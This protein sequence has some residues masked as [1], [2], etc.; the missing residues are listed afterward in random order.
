M[1]Q[2]LADSRGDSATEEQ[3]VRQWQ[4]RVHAK[5]PLNLASTR[6]GQKLTSWLTRRSWGFLMVVAL[7]IA[8]LMLEGGARAAKFEP[9]PSQ[10]SFPPVSGSRCFDS[11]DNAW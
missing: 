7:S 4:V 1:P 2:S 6:G 3:S 5:Y 11:V 9:P 8:L 10:S